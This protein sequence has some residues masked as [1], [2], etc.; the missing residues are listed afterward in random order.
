MM[1]GRVK[2]LHPHIHGGLLGVRDDPAHA[3][4]MAEHGIAGI[5]L[6]V[7]NLYPFE[8]TVGRGADPADA[9][10]NIDIGGPAMIRAAAKNHAYV[11]VVA[12]PADYAAISRTRRLRT[13][14]TTLALRQRSRPRPSPAPPPTTPP[15][16]PGSP[17]DAGESLPDAAAVSPA[18]LAAHAP[19]RREPA[20]SRRRFT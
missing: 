13:A 12:E 2:T 17:P 5:D 10:E 9:I 19:L 20:P 6:L 7:V 18:R 4:A 15:S 8:A 3:A 1:D 11:A 16:P 14:A